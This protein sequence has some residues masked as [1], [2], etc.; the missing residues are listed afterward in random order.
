M[1]ILTDHNALK[2]RRKENDCMNIKFA[3][4][5]AGFKKGLGGASNAKGTEKY[6]YVL[7]GIQEDTQHPENS[8][9]YFEYDDQRNGAINSVESVSFGR[10]SVVFELKGGKSIQIDCDVSMA[11]WKEL[12]R[13]VR[14]V[15]PENTVSPF[16][17]RRSG[18]EKSSK[19]PR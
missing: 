16:S 2:E 5:E 17:K 10:K 15:F 6:H 1:D 19:K 9:V 18:P 14:A 12:E 13:G 4:T 7:F 11:R 8:G 3:A